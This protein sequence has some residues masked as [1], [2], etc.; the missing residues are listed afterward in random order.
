[1]IAYSSTHSV[2]CA[3]CRAS[4]WRSSSP[5]AAAARVC[6]CAYVG[7][8]AR[9]RFGRCS[10]ARDG[11]AQVVELDDDEARAIALALGAMIRDYAKAGRPTPRQVVALYRRIDQACEVSSRRQL[12]VVRREE[13]GESRVGSRQ[14]AA[15]L[16]WNV[17]RVQRHVADLGGEMVGDRLIFDERAVRQYAEALQQK[18][19]R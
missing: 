15:L 6:A 8:A 11:A 18:E 3:G 7:I 1:M 17:R 14:A 13:L 5:S 16:G 9:C 19:S 2:V 4:S 12:E 10:L